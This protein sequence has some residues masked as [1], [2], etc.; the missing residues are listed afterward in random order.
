MTCGT[1]QLYCSTACS[2]CPTT[3]GATY[4]CDSSACVARTC[5]AGYSVVGPRCIDSDWSY[6]VLDSSADY[7]SDG[8][9]RSAALAL[10]PSG[11]VYVAYVDPP[12]VV[13]ARRSGTAWTKT[14]VTL[15]QP[16]L[17]AVT[18]LAVDAAGNAHV[19][20]YT[21]KALTSYSSTD[22]FR[23]AKI[24]SAGQVSLSLELGEV[25]TYNGG[26]LYK[27]EGVALAVDS[28]GDAHVAYNAY[29]SG[30]SRL[31]YRRT[32]AGAWLAPIDVT[33][34][35]TFPYPSLLVDANGD[36]HIA[37]ANGSQ[38][39]YVKGV[40]SLFGTPLTVAGGGGG[41]TQLV[42]VGSTLEIWS[43]STAG[44]WVSTVSATALSAPVAWFTSTTTL[45]YA[46]GVRSAAGYSL[47]EQQT[48]DGP[49]TARRGP[50]SGPTLTEVSN[51]PLSWVEN[52]AVMD[53][54]GTMH[55][56]SWRYGSSGDTLTYIR[57]H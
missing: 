57:G 1:G 52:T 27:N 51:L 3:G 5:A 30:G 26:T 38:V 8:Q 34:A 17:T 6:E 35:T 53:A 33:T 48:S 13:I 25:A 49:V 47:V 9:P 43:R 24:N 40:N 44:V 11:S 54:A 42:R 31:Q 28:A 20:Y 14:P 16:G 23:Y 22:A 29:S 56:L 7:F 12:N 2:N 50:A 39:L 37:G 10:S 46:S 19:I 15:G 21:Y 36:V 18:N 45:R 4:G 55:A 41:D 32:F